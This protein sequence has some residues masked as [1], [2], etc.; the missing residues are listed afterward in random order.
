[1]TKSNTIQGLDAAGAGTERKEVKSR[2]IWANVF[3]AFATKLFVLIVIFVTVPI[4]VYD[5]LRAADEDNKLLLMEGA[6][7]QGR[8]VAEIL[9]PRLG[10][11]T[12]KL[13]SE[14]TAALGSLDGA[15]VKVKLLYRPSDATKPFGF[16]YVA[17]IPAVTTEYLKRERSELIERGVLAKVRATCATADPIA[18]RYIN[19]SGRLEVLTSLTPIET[20]SGCWVVITSHSSAD[21]VSSSIGRPYWMTPEILGASTIYLLM[22]LFATL[23][24]LDAWH[25]VRMFRGLAHGIRTGR[26][27]ETS[28]AD[29]NRVPELAGVAHEFDRLIEKLHNSADQMRYAAEENAHAFKTPIAVISQSIEPLKRGA[30]DNPGVGRAVGRIERS[31][32][33]LDALVTAARQMEEMTA[34]LLDQPLQKVELLEPMK[35]IVQAYGVAQG[36]SGPEIVLTASATPTVNAGEDLLETVIENLLDNAIGFSPPGGK[37]TLSLDQDGSDALITVD[38]QGSGVAEEKLEQIFERYYSERD[39]TTR[40]GGGDSHEHFG[41]GL[42]IVRRNV[43]S[44]GG[45]ITA[46]NSAQG[47]LRVRVRIPAI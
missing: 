33:R 16:Y 22:A 1:M 20:P 31:V 11:V 5:Q 25:S 32:E 13:V 3:R 45:R 36:E 46:E 29:F 14:L 38:D 42:W 21:F 39:E 6:R 44:I 19:P 26:R 9:R 2:R 43:E 7:Q 10:Q 18:E 41:I 23:L 15:A 35:R 24:Y 37:V 4:I 12:P 27:G 40:T 28:F 8:M 34:E 30:E 47:G 17:S